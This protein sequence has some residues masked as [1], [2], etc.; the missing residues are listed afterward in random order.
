MKPG[1]TDEWY[2]PK[3]FFDSFNVEF[4]LDPCH[5]DHKTFVPAKKYY[6]KQQNGLDKKWEGLVW[7]N[8]PFGGKNGYFCW[9]DKFLEHGNGIGLFTALTS[10]KGFQKYIPHMDAILF[11]RTKTRF[12]QE[13]GNQGKCP[14]NGVVLFAK[15]ERSVEILRKSNLGLFINLKDSKNE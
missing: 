6:T 3:Y 9:V 15:G 4:D 7:M 14:F 10:S 11:P 13:D 1:I 2:T 5:P 12:I 8:P